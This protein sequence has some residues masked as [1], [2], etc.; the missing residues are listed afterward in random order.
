MKT[1]CITD[2]DIMLIWQLHVICKSYNCIYIYCRA[3]DS[4]EFLKPIDNNKGK[5]HEKK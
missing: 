5:V 2:F 4:A 1:I 3:T